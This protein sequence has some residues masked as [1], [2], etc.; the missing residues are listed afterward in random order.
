MRRTRAYFAARDRL[1]RARE[2]F[3]EIEELAAQARV[4]WPIKGVA[5]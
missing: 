4:V 2:E 5:A 3:A 1:M